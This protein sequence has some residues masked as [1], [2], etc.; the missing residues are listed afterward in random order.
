MFLFILGPPS[1]PEGP[2]QFS[3]ITA[4]SCTVHWKAP[5]SDGGLPLRHYIVE[6]RDAKR[7]TWVEVDRV[8]PKMLTCDASR[9][10][11]GVEYQFQVF[12]EN[13]EGKSPA[14]EA[15]EPI[16]CRKAPGE[17]NILK[18]FIFTPCC[19]CFLVDNITS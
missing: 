16:V 12:A 9:L 14:L 17:H 18:V 11:E 3:D 13:D 8:R 6:R 4:S 15:K 5:K 1:A 2:M 7:Q 10:I 19:C